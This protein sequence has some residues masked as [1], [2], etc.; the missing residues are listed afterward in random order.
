ME[1]FR[2][3]LAFAKTD[4]NIK[5]VSQEEFN[6]E[7]QTAVTEREQEADISNFEDTIQALLSLAATSQSITETQSTDD[8]QPTTSGTSRNS[9]TSSKSLEV[10]KRRHTTVENKN[11]SSVSAIVN[12]FEQKK[13][14]RRCE[15]K[16]QN[17]LIFAG[18]AQ[19]VNSFSLK[20]QSITRLKIA[21]IISEQE[22][23][24]IEEMESISRP[25]DVGTCDVIPSLTPLPASSSEEP[26]YTNLQSCTTLSEDINSTLSYLSQFQ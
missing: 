18:Y 8:T 25:S 3:F 21:Q 4:S 17:D 10:S 6:T 16:N 11:D 15:N 12:Y 22:L 7:P 2:P 19:A 5:N 23:L 14:E 13:K 20:R 24:N 26:T 9:F 1:F